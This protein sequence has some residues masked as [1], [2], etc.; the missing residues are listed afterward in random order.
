MSIITTEGFAGRAPNVNL[1]P[2]QHLT[3]GFPV[4]S[5]GPTPVV[6][7]RAWELT[8]TTTFGHVHHWDFAGLTELQAEDIVVDLHC[9]TRWS[10]LGTRWRGVPVSALLE[11]VEDAEA[12]NAM[13][14]S[15]G[16][17]STNVPREDL[18]DGRAWLVFDFE[19]HP[20]SAEHG[21]PVRLLV[22]HLYLWKS[23]KWLNGLTLM[24]HDEPGFWESLGY[25]LY[26]DPWQE[27][28]HSRD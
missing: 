27:Q 20:L 8:L 9:V 22:P 10:K 25:H 16:G 1:P 13:A 3:Q 26:G 4:L 15:Y 19:G 14:H 23:A 5:S 17:Y 28:R 11:G 24:P 12:R 2:G 6:P 18:V 21:G 7:R